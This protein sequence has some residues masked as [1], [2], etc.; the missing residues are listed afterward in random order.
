MPYWQNRR[1]ADEAALEDDYE[2]PGGRCVAMG[3]Q[4]VWR[5]CENHLFKGTHSWCIRCAGR[6]HRIIDE[7]KFSRYAVRAM[8][9]EFLQKNI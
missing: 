6:H 2:Q 3:G 7:M 1:T 5:W 8:A 9:A 4:L